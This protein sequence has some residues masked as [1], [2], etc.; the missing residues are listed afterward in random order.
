MKIANKLA[1][2][3]SIRGGTT[4]ISATT[5]VEGLPYPCLD[6]SFQRHWIQDLAVAADNLLYRIKSDV[7]LIDRRPRGQ[8]TFNGAGTAIAIN[9]FAFLPANNVDFDVRTG[10]A[11]GTTGFFV[12]EL[13]GLYWCGLEF[14]MVAASANVTKINLEVVQ[15]DSAGANLTPQVG[16][17]FNNATAAATL[18]V[19]NNPVRMHM[20]GMAHVSNVAY[21]LRARVRHQG[22]VTM[23]P[24]SVNFAIQY[25][26]GCRNQKIPNPSF[27]RNISGWVV[28]ASNTIAHSGAQAHRGNYSLIVTAPAGVSDAGVKTSPSTVPGVAARVYH[29]I[30]YVY[31]TVAEGYTLSIRWLNSGGGLISTST[32]TATSLANGWKRYAL[33][34]TSPAN[35]ALIEVLVQKNVGG[36]SPP[37]PYWIDDAELFEFC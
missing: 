13:P 23:Q 2:K 34:A 5:T 22:T 17:S 27:E 33:T 6:G 15:C 7:D 25:L 28:A 11:T 32:V 19:T 37:P 30:V 4:N 29:A 14:A 21:Q 35:T 10:A 1:G 18:P 3:L 9:T 20:S 36:I 26:G 16:R 24:G 12:P 8:L 31:T